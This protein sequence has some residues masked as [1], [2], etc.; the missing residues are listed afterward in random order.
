M[1]EKAEA[2]ILDEKPEDNKKIGEFETIKQSDPNV[3]I[4]V[5]WD[6]HEDNEEEENNEEYDDEEDE[7]EDEDEED[8]DEEEEEEEEER[9]EEEKNVKEVSKRRCQRKKKIKSVCLDYD[10][11]EQEEDEEEENE[12]EKSCESYEFSTGSSILSA[13]TFQW[14][15]KS[16]EFEELCDPGTIENIYNK[17]SG[18]NL[19]S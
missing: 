13:L 18:K 4:S 10:E 3:D 9:E 6:E 5:S 1:G 2:K 15:D 7:D 12:N 19:I 11:E 8:D 16:Y 14:N 17:Y